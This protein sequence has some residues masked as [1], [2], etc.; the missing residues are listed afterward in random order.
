MSS[1]EIISLIVTVIGVFSFATI[2]TI[3]YKSYTTSQIEEIKSGKKDIELIDEVIYERQAD[4]KKRRKVFRIVRS[5]LF[6]LVLI[7][8]IPIF[9]FSLVNRFQNNVTMLGNKTLMVVASGSMSEKHEKNS[10]LINNDSDSKLNYQFNTY[11]IIILEKVQ[12]ENDLQLYDVIAY[13]NNDGINVIHR[14]KEIENGTYETRGDANEQSD[15]YHPVFDDVIGKYNGKKIAGLGMFI[16]FLQSYAGIITIVSLIYCLLMIDHFSGKI[17]EVQTL[18]VKL[19]EEAIDYSNESDKLTI[20]AKF[21]ETIYYKGY[22][23]QFDENGFI[24]KSKINEGPYLE[25][26]NEAIIKEVFNKETS[27]VTSKKIVLDDDKQGE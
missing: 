2:F 7:I 26:S 10:Y 5:I 17:D 15:T 23:Y 21:V 11:D 16:M 19:L 6:Y 25:K 4:V 8:V 14:I 3:L 18:R 20:E 1:V 13:V 27:E 9:I 12:N 22:A 24:D